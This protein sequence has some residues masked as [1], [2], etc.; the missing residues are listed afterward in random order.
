MG[1]IKKLFLVENKRYALKTD[2]NKLFIDYNIELVYPYRRN[3]KEKLHLI[4]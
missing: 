3:Q 2:K 1:F 4:F